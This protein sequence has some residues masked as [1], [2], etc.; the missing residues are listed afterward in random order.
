[1][2][3]ELRAGFVAGITALV[4]IHSSN[5]ADPMPSKSFSEYALAAELGKDQAYAVELLIDHVRMIHDEDYWDDAMERDEAREAADY[6]PAFT[7]KQVEF[8]AGKLTE[9]EEWISLQRVSGKQPLRDITVLRFLP[10]LQG[11][12]LG[13]NEVTSLDPLNGMGELRRLHLDENKI[14]NLSPLA[15]CTKLEELSVQGNPVE[16]FS[17]IVALPNLKK[18]SISWYQVPAL[19]KAVK[20]GSLQELDISFAGDSEREPVPLESLAVLPEMPELRQLR[21]VDS[22][23]LKG[24]GRF[25]RLLNLVNFGGDVRSLEPLSEAPNLTSIN[26]LDSKVSDLEPL[27]KLPRLRSLCLDT[28]AAEVSLEPLRR[29]PLLHDV[30]VR[31]QKKE[32]DALKK[33]RAG[34]SSWDSEFLA[35]NA[36]YKADLK[37]QVVSKDEF[38]AIDH[39]APYGTRNPEGDLGVLGSEL[40]WLDKRIATVFDRKL[41]E[42]ED[43]AI[44]HQWQECR[45]RDVHLLTPKSMDSLRAIAGGIQEILCHTKT[46]W[47]IYLEADESYTIWIYPDKVVVA[48]EQAQLVKGLLG[49]E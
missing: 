42:D 40:D 14:R 24:I 26:I 38:K 43:F 32:P 49:D 36:R 37:L 30:T 33:L 23:S 6:T 21:G 19:G 48:E 31:C 46:D 18:L 47:I 16:D 44:P 28:D 3:S 45:W 9:M 20:L 10:G 22:H 7:K 39:K 17:A 15:R 11:L 27:T 2:H 34:L 1:M 13:N 29:A 5:A 41:V 4:M 8:A 25:P 35:K 12:A